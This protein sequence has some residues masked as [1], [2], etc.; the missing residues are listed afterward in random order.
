MLEDIL[1]R[2]PGCFSPESKISLGKELPD[3]DLI[4]ADEASRSVI[5]AELKWLRKPVNWKER[6]DRSEDFEKGLRQVL[7]IKAFLEKE[8]QFLKSRGKLKRNLNEYRDVAFF[9]VARDQFEWPTTPDIT[10]A[11]HVVF[12][13][14]IAAK[15]D[16]AT[17]IQELKA[18]DWLPVEGKDFEVRFE[19]RTA[20][21]VTAESEV[22]YRIH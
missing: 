4:L 17:S 22:F 14:K 20:N 12:Q 2:L 1:P 7:E 8:P 11:D 18:Y 15:P 3:I 9:V 21:G 5:V 13:R 19:P 16:L 10:V 6:I